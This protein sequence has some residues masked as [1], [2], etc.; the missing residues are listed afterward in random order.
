MKTIFLF[1]LLFWS[2]R[3]MAQ[4]SDSLQFAFLQASIAGYQRGNS[5]ELLVKNEWSVRLQKQHLLPKGFQVVNEPFAK[6]ACV[7]PAMA[8]KLRKARGITRFDIST[9]QADTVDIVV[10]YTP[11]LIYREKISFWHSRYFASENNMAPCGQYRGNLPEHLPV[12]YR[13]YVFSKACN[14][15]KF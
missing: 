2:D 6:G 13:R 7:T 1:T 4:V 8:K 11:Y 12:V 10:T 14:C 9:G 15:W 5:L 3:E